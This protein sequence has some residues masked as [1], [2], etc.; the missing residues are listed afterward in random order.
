MTLPGTVVSEREQITPR[1]APTNT[2]VWF[3]AGLAERGPLTPTPIRSMQALR[4]IFGERTN[5]SQLSDS[6]EAA[7]RE[8]ATLIYVSRVVGPAATSAT[9]DLKNATD[10]ACLRVKAANV[11]DYANAY[12]VAVEVVGATFRVV[13]TD[14]DA[15]LV[16]RSPYFADKASAVAY[17][18]TAFVI[19]SLVGT[20]NPKAAAAAAMTGGADD[21]ASVT[22]A[23]RVAAVNRF[24]RDL[25]PG[26]V[27]IPGASTAAAHEGLLTHARDR[28]RRALL[29]VPDTADEATIEAASKAVRDLGDLARFGGFFTRGTLPGLTAG[30]TRSVP[31]SAFAAGA[32][33]RVDAAGNPNVPAAGENGILAS[34]VGVP[35][36]FDDAQREALNDA[37]VNVIRVVFGQVR[38][39]GFRTV[40][41]KDAAPNHWQLA[42]VRLDMA[43][44]ARGA[45]IAERFV[46]RPID[47]KGHTTSE[48][49]GE[50][51]AMLAE[52]YRLGALYGDTADDAFS[53]DVGP[54]VNTPESIA[55]G[56]LRAVLA[57]RRSPMGEVVEVEVVKVAVTDAV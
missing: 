41:A 54:A 9:I 42:N 27:S 1:T 34:A 21:R 45:A 4:R 43:I 49:A 6:V 48:F 3:V 53:V 40:A 46:F 26:Q 52:F 22:D 13:V 7:F 14:A 17:Q 36:S 30:T 39:Y 16:E 11:G 12:K 5:Y 23:D 29:D 25:G 38:I 8:G 28:N 10:V 50:L 35:Y 18:P 15:E 31:G 51:S 33:A 24:G 2:G 55:D 19:E 56:H 47:G 20:G 44:A 57:I 37:G 32:M